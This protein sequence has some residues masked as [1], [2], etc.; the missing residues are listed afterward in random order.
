MVL[1]PHT[2]SSPDASAYIPRPGAGT[3]SDM[4][5]EQFTLRYDGDGLAS[6][7]MDVRQL[8]PS[9]LALGELFHA[10]QQLL[11]RDGPAVRVDIVA[12]PEPGSLIVHLMAAHAEVMQQAANLLNSGVGTAASLSSL[13]RNVVDLLNLIKRAG[14][15]DVRSEEPLENGQ[16][17]S[18]SRTAPR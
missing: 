2:D 9:L 7:R 15:E 17:G 5:E 18:R 11:N 16:T 12:S 4:A 8:A 13:I 6:G 3:G 10:S 1:W 14:G